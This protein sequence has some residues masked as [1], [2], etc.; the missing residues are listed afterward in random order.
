MTTRATPGACPIKDH[1]SQSA[2]FA[3]VH[4]KERYRQMSKTSA[5]MTNMQLLLTA[6]K[7]RFNFFVNAGFVREVITNMY[8]TKSFLQI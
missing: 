8:D 1:G 5:D 3:C 6:G 2:R 7:L 4:I